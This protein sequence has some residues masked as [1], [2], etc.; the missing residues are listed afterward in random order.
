MPDSALVLVTGFGPF[1]QVDRNPSGELARLLEACPPDGFEVIGT[2]LPVTFEGAGT[3]LRDFVASHRDRSPAF[4][5][6]LGVQRTPAFRLERNARARLDSQKPDNEGRRASGV[7]VL[8]ERDLSTTFDLEALAPCLQADE[9]EPVLLSEDAGGF[10]CERTYYELLVL[11]EELG[12][13]ALFLHVP[14]WDAMA[15]ER[16]VVHVRALLS[17]M[18]R[19]L[20][21]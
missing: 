6:S 10:V 8:G 18:Q 20:G 9:L 11:S 5:L 19:F 14:P 17:E 15:P 7:A 21:A 13:P 12:V 1:F 3:A 16:Q 4:L 2:E